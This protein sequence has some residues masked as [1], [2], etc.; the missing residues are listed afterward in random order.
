MI[1]YFVEEGLSKAEVA[2]RLGV[3]RQTVYN[4]VKREGPY[5]KPRKRRASKL[6]DPWR[7]RPDGEVGEGGEVDRALRDR[8]G[9]PGTDRLCRVRHRDSG[10]PQEEVVP[11]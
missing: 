11:V 4:H 6:D 1:R 3:S 7:F 2:R 9:S 8:A 10:W 5:V